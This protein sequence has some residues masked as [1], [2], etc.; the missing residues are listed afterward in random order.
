[1][2]PSMFS[3]NAA[4]NP[5]W[6]NPAWYERDRPLFRRYIPLIREVA[7]A[8]WSPVT[9]AVYGDASVLVEKFGPNANGTTYYTLFN[10]GSER[11]SAV[12][13]L[14]SGS[15]EDQARL[16]VTELLKGRTPAWT[17]EGW[18]IDIEPDAVV[19]VRMEPAAR[20]RSVAVDFEGRLRL[21]VAAPVGSTQVLETSTNLGHWESLSTNSMDTVP[22]EL[23]D[24]I[25]ASELREYYRLRM[26][27]RE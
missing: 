14:T 6:R 11:S 25:V 20:F 9:G 27:V 10:E 15:T 18:F 26:A 19:V 24:R 7:E 17:G 13:Q 23:P 2:F 16:A 22:M 5:Y 12:F 8:G 3:H 1:M 4:E 21:T